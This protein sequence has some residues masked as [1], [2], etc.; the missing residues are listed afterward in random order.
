MS[1]LGKTDSTTGREGLGQRRG[2]LAPQLEGRRMLGGSWAWLRNS[3]GG[4][5]AHFLLGVSMFSVNEG[6]NHLL[7]QK[8]DEE[9][10]EVS[11]EDRKVDTASGSEE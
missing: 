11:G 7:R 4:K 5:H 3:K 10:E 8:M 2:G 9:V 1:G 6:A